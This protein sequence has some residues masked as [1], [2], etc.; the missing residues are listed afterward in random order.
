MLLSVLRPEL[1]CWQGAFHHVTFSESL[2][3]K[4]IPYRFFKVPDIF[5][6]LACVCED[7]DERLKDDVDWLE[8]VSGTGHINMA[9]LNADVAR[10]TEQTWDDARDW[11]LLAPAPKAL[12]FRHRL[13]S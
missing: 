2:Q 1:S 5:G 7:T 13:R 6:V 3:D 4:P 9:K 12:R 10:L 11:K 8:A